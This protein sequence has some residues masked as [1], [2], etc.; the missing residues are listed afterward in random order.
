MFISFGLKHVSHENNSSDR[1]MVEVNKIT[2]GVI[3]YRSTHKA[4]NS[5]G[6]SSHIFAKNIGVLR[7][8]VGGSNPPH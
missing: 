6:F 7:G 3:Y 8:E 4:E 5:E 2:L 1:M